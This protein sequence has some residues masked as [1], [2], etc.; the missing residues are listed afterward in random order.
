M[1]IQN[2]LE[3][4]KVLTDNNRLEG[5]LLSVLI[6]V[7][8]TSRRRYPKPMRD[9]E[10]FTKFVAEEMKKITGFVQN[11]HLKFRNNI[12]T[13]QD[14]LYKFVRCELAHEAEVPAD[15]V[16]EKGKHRYVVR[17][18]KII[19]PYELIN[20]LARAVIEATENAKD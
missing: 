10:A 5:A 2:R 20:G 7:A 6:A 3:D 12:M 8:A 11:F 13:L 1:S 19:L 16:F 18:D 4:A 17:D 9:K 14:L 15:I